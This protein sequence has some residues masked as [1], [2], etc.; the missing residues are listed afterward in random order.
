MQK[1]T[2]NAIFTLF[3][4]RENCNSRKYFRYIYSTPFG[5]LL[6]DRNWAVGTD[7]RYGFNGKENDDEIGGNNN[8]L[9]FGE[10]IYDAR[11]WRWFSMD[12]IAENNIDC[13]PYVAFENNPIYYLDPEGES[14]IAKKSLF[15]HKITIKANLYCYG[16][17][18]S[19]SNAKSTAQSIEN[20][21]NAAHGKVTIDGVEYS[22]KFKIKGKFKSEEQATK[23]AGKNTS[24]KNNFVRM[25]SHA[26][27]G[28]KAFS[29]WD[30]F[31]NSGYLI[32]DQSLTTA[33]HEFIHGLGWFDPTQ[34]VPQTLNGKHDLVGNTQSG[35]E[36]PD[37]TIPG[38]MTPEET[39]SADL[40]NGLPPI[41]EEYLKENGSID[42]N[43]RIVTQRDLNLTF[44]PKI[45]FGKKRKVDMVGRNGL[46]NII[47][48]KFS[49]PKN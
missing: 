5:M 9:D 47:F 7:Y 36:G 29:G 48:D 44:I 43:K 34:N 11:L 3:L 12:P 26:S 1:F 35:G 45:H 8:D 22:V 31:T 14:A 15:G 32:I 19:K 6:V 13:S 41:G 20:N 21:L 33:T 38:I 23:L 37:Y 30:W 28:S 10:R 40:L 25:E 4:K 42:L 46:S 27:V 17:L 24:A 2:K 39:T 18:A 16:T 49:K